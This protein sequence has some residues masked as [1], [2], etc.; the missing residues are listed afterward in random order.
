M[1]LA[2]FLLLAAV[3]TA[4]AQ[5]TRYT[6]RFP[7]A[8]H[9]EA[10]VEARFDNIP[11]STTL[12]LRMARSSPGR[13]APA[14]FAMNVSNVRATDAAG[15][16]LAVSRPNP[17]Q[18]NV[19]SG[20]GTVIVRYT[21]YAP[22]GNGTWSGI[23]ASRVLL[24]GPATWMWARSLT[25]RPITVTIEPPA[26]PAWKIAT[27]LQQQQTGANT[28]RAPH[29][30]YLM[31][32]P[33]L[34]SA[35]LQFREWPAA[36][37]QRI[38]LALLQPT[39]PEGEARVS[40]FAKMSEAVVNELEGVIGELPRFDFGLYTFLVDLMPQTGGDG[41]EHRNSTV[42]A[43]SRGFQNPNSPTGP[44]G[45][46]SHEF[47]HAWNVERIRPKTLEPFNFEDVNISRELWFAEGFTSYYGPLALRRARI[48]SQEEFIRDMSRAVN[49]VLASPGREVF[50]AVEM[51]EW[52]PFADGS[53]STLGQ[54]NAQNVFISY[55]PYGEA[56][57]LGLDLAIRSEFPNKSLDDFMQAMWQRFGRHQQ[58]HKPEKPY[59]LADLEKTLASVTSPQ[60]AARIFDRHIRSKSEPMDYAALLAKAGF[61]VRK[62]AKPQPWIGISA[63]RGGGNAAFNAQSGAVT[64]TA[65]PL[66]GSPLYAAGLDRG[67]RILQ[68][69]GRALKNMGDLQQWL[70]GKKP[71][72]TAKLKVE[73][74]AD[75]APRDLTVTI[76]ARPGV[77]IVSFEAAGRTLT[78]EQ[79]SF[80]KSWL[81]SKARRPQPE[82]R[83]YCS[84][85]VT[86]PFEF[87]FCPNDGKPAQIIP[88]PNR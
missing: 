16:T 52:A 82:L 86:V 87:D 12:E 78:P 67:D 4:D 65:S 7:N 11:G 57:A 8:I 37:Q 59:T 84:D 50:S 9:H 55:Y 44:I 76:A 60:F 72:D 25:E 81:A 46:V 75:A 28:F 29:L 83:R 26:N 62:P 68:F 74:V 3:I 15:K 42:V 79:E 70:E 61:D 24:N 36:E 31:D 80:R 39:S 53:G 45:T 33:I 58:N 51:S 18:W 6:I 34:A 5:E 63:G 27:Q 23:D 2:L 56:I 43:D 71:G 14:E 1:P 66:K 40:A 73:T 41:M 49:A 20:S 47:F 13:Y 19:Q 69:D 54:S 22:N 64:I 32:S 17:Y 85:G 48:Q 35:N 77:E 10:E 30:D 21:L 38:R 88:P